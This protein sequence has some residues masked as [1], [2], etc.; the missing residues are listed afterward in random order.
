[1]AKKKESKQTKSKVEK[2]KDKKVRGKKIGSKSS[3]AQ[4]EKQVKIV[5]GVM[6]AILILIAIAF[7]MSKSMNI[8]KYAGLKFEKVK[9][10]EIYIYAAK[11]PIIENHQIVD[12]IYVN[13]RNNPKKT[14]EEVKVNLSTGINLPYGSNLVYISIDSETEKCEDAGIAIINLGSV[15]FK[16]IGLNTKIASYNKSFAELRGHPYISCSS[17]SKDA[18]VFKIQPSNK[19]ITQI[20]EI[21]PY[22]YVL[23]YKDCDDLVKLTERLQLA[24]IEQY[25]NG[26]EP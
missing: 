20:R 23:E 24:I 18:G 5:V 25:M 6:I 9:Y 15:F 12:W 10:G 16:N 11:V 19:D 1:M 17:A 13:L 2:S 14:A 4:M 22:C 26:L 3:I 7:L 21:V 8:T